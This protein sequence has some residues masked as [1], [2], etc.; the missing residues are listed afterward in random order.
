MAADVWSALPDG[1]PRFLRWED[2]QWELSRAWGPERITTGWW[3]GSYI[4]R[5]YYQVEVPD[6]RRFWLFRELRT[7]KW[8]LH[9]AFD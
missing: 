4:R 7:G 8:F 5:D 9:A 3:R 6:G 1:P 2:D